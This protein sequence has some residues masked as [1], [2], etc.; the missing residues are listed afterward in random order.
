MF[1]TGDCITIPAGYWHSFGSVDNP[2]AFLT[3]KWLTHSSGIPMLHQVVRMH[4]VG[5]TDPRMKYFVPADMKLHPDWAEFVAE[6][7]NAL[8]GPYVNRIFT[9]GADS[10]EEGPRAESYGPKEVL[11]TLGLR[12][13]RF[14]SVADLSALAHEFSTYKPPGQLLIQGLYTKKWGR[15][16]NYCKAA[17]GLSTTQMERDAKRGGRPDP[18][19]PSP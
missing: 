11:E 1:T 19:L 9:W 3:A 15:L 5:K 4:K 8:L 12:R 16:T 2:T 7:T 14:N 10:G 18:E 6:A 13:N 17:V